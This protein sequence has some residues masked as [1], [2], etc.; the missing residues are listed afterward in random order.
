LLR[1]MVVNALVSMMSHSLVVVGML[2]VMFR[3][4]PSLT[5]VAVALV[6]VLYAILSV[7]RIRLV[8][9]AQRQRKREG[10]LA[11]SAQEIL[12][13]IHLVQANTAE[14]HENLRF[15]DMNKRSLRA[16]LGSARLEAQLNRAVLVAIAAGISGVLW[17]GTRR[18]M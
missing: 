17:L 9:A 5:L 10:A 4:E 15:K 7:F 16:S 2:V 18:V 14:R 12:Q 8:E 3:M 1:E 11:S 13:G 6:P